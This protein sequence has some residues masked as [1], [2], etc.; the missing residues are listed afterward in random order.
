M[1][2]ILWSIDIPLQV[3]ST[4]SILVFAN[5]RDTPYSYING[6]KITLR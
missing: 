4:F 3:E 2:Y 5:F 1:Y 6:I